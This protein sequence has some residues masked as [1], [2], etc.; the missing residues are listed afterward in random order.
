MQLFCNTYHFDNDFRARIIV[1][2]V[3]E[4]DD[5]DPE[6]LDCTTDN[7]IRNLRNKYPFVSDMTQRS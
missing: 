5:R 6:D 2:I 3:L 1:V 4:R 7:Y